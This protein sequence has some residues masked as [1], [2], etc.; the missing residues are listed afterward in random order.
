MDRD[1]PNRGRNSSIAEMSDGCPED[2]Q[3]EYNGR[4]EVIEENASFGLNKR[5]AA[6]H[7]DVQQDMQRQIGQSHR[8]RD[9]ILGKYHRASP[10]TSASVTADRRIGASMTPLRFGRNISVGWGAALVSWPKCRR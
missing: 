5:S 3:R 8:N 9:A 2:H 1:Q 10:L 6:K 4:N 7:E